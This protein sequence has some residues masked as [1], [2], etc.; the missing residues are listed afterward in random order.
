MTGGDEKEGFIS[1]SD[2]QNRLKGNATKK[3]T[4]LSAR[5]ELETDEWYFFA[6]GCG[7]EV[8]ASTSLELIVCVIQLFE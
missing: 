8:V 7:L 6:G 1:C 5:Y 4:G 2:R 3:Y